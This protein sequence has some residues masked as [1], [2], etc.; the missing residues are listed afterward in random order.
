MVALL[1][2]KTIE[3]L[4]ETPIR[5]KPIHLRMQTG[6]FAAIESLKGDVYT[7]IKAG[8]QEDILRLQKESQELNVLRERKFNELALY[9]STQAQLDKLSNTKNEAMVVCILSF[10]AQYF[11]TQPDKLLLICNS[12]APGI[13]NPNLVTRGLAILRVIDL[14]ALRQRLH[15][16]SLYILREEYEG[17]QTGLSAKS[18]DRF[19]AVQLSSE[20]RGRHGLNPETQVFV[21]REYY[22]W[23]C[24]PPYIRVY[25]PWTKAPD[26]TT[27]DWLE[28]KLNTPEFV[29][30]LFSLYIKDQK[31]QEEHIST[32]LSPQQ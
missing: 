14:L 30:K 5:L 9:L 28:E 19:A 17:T 13:V 20:V 10:L 22:G 2:L 3:R 7:T 12:L 8:L 1:A 24:V 27:G 11:D 25:K 26:A 32:S 23:L 18:P 6:S 15:Q 29:Q 21:D 31:D 16:Q 4:L